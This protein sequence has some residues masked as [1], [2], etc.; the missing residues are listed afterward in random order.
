MIP[1]LLLALGLSAVE[2]AAADVAP[3]TDCAAPL[4]ARVP[5][6]ATAALAR[7]PDP[8]RRLL[9]LQ[10]YLHARDLPT[11]WSWDEARIRAYQGSAEQLAAQAALDRVQSA[12][13]AANPGY[14]LHVNTQVRS[15]DV[16]LAHWNENASV[17]EAAQALVVDAGQACREAPGRFEAWLRAWRP[18]VRANLAA[19]GLSAHGQAHAFDFQVIADPSGVLVAGTDSRRID[20]DWRTGGWAARLQAAITASG[21]PFVGPLASPDEPWHYAW[22]PGPPAAR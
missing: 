1:S 18:A 3:P 19:P 2:P 5:E 10:A 6:V 9:A 22:Q 16:Q 14:Q 13:R 11:R 4:A 15:L 12:F 20:A 17:A 7:I 8:G 21:M